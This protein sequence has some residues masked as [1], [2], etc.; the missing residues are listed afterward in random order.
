M[1]QKIKARLIALGLV[2]EGASEEEFTAALERAVE[3]NLDLRE[4][5]DPE[6]PPAP[7]PVPTPDVPPTDLVAAERARVAAIE[8]VAQHGRIDDAT[9]RG[10][11]ANGTDEI[12][13]SRQA[14]A[15]VARR[16]LP[17][18]SPGRVQFD[19]PDPVA[20]F[21]RSA[22]VAFLRM[23][24]VPD[25]SIQ[26]TETLDHRG[27]MSRSYTQETLASAPRWMSFRRIAL[28]LVRLRS[29]VDLQD[30]TTDEILRSRAFAHSTS[31]FANILENV[32]TKILVEAYARA[33]VTYNR[34]TRRRDVANFLP[35]SRPKLGDVP[36]FGLTPELMPLGHVTFGDGKETIQAA[37]YGLAFGIS[38]QAIVNDDLDAFARLPELIG[39]AA[40]RTINSAVYA[41]I[42][43]NSQVMAE[44]GEVIFSASHT[45]G[46]N[47]AATPAVPS[48][49]SLGV[50]RSDMRKQKGL[51]GTE[52]LNLTP[53]F[54]L[55]PPE[56]E[57]TF[58]QLQTTISAESSGNVVPSFVRSLDLVVDAA[59]TDAADWFLASS[60]GLIDTVEV[61]RLQG[62]DGPVIERQDSTDILG[63]RWNAYIDFAA[64]AM[65]HRGLYANK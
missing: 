7:A 49:T 22:E 36:N 37:T 33:P 5:G 41:L 43:A 19:G 26:A 54:I 63:V 59:L 39:A 29:N 48:V 61:A 25:A 11:I 65:E 55:S 16:E 47:L 62:Q 3:Q 40:A 32:A 53:A 20:Q 10:W 50:A 9:R 4:R 60:P 30:L 58:E 31:D 38:R 42:N 56:L 46:R 52:S 8:R 1:N 18:S 14:L 15:I 23:R 57:T 45:S 35:I 21:S 27:R 64:R 13:A 24:S 28:E 17:V 12:E 34:W 2:A 6:P 44:D 51:G